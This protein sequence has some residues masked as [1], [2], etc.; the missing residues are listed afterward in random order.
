MEGAEEIKE[1][2]KALRKSVR[3][4]KLGE[5]RKVQQLIIDPPKGI[6]LTIKYPVKEIQEE[7]ASATLQPSSMGEEHFS[8]YN[9]HGDETSTLVNHYATKVNPA[10][11]VNLQTLGVSC[12]IKMLKH[13]FLVLERFTGK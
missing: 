10:W 12:K 8:T 2:R 3:R 5:K 7:G 4:M 11:K 9:A 1:S 6:I 13:Q